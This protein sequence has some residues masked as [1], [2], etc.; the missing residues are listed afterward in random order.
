MSQPD[1][2]EA[3]T[4]PFG[5][6]PPQEPAVVE[7]AP[8][9]Q[10]SSNTRTILEI[11]GAVVAVGA[12]FVAG[13]VGFGAGWFAAKH[14]KRY[15]DTPRMTMRYDSQGDQAVPG[16]PDFPGFGQD[17]PNND[18]NADPFG[19]NGGGMQQMPELPD[20]LEQW[21]E[22]FGE[23]LREGMEGGQDSAPAPDAPSAPPAP[24]AAPSN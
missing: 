16:I 1:G 11:V 21:L 19:G 13:V 9:E 17:G 2:P 18:G 22:Q 6:V 12:I 14:D 7:P 10:K 3:E 4:Q 8:V 15:D 20:D 24:S 23:Q 5:A